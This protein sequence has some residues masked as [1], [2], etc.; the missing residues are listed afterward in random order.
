MRARWKRWLNRGEWVTSDRGIGPRVAV[1]L[2]P[3]DG[4]VVAIHPDTMTL[5]EAR[6]L[7]NRLIEAAAVAE[8]MEGLR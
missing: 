3:G 8:V 7:G 1:E 4:L 6:F 2:L 5:D